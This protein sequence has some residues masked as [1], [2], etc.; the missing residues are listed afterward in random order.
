VDTAWLPLRPQVANKQYAT[1]RND[2]EMHC[3]GR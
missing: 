1:V 3:D 2:Y